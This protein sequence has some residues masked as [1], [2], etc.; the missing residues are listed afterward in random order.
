[1]SPFTE[2]EIEYLRGQPLGRLATVGTGGAPHISPVGFRVNPEQGTIEIG[3]H[4]MGASKKWRDLQANQQVAFVI[5]DLESVNPWTPRGI[6]IRGRAEMH[7][8]GGQE[9]FGEGW[10][11]AWFAVVPQ[12]IVSWGIERPAFSEG[13]RNARSV[14]PA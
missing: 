2:K 7:D 13:G 4:G 10:D 8:A 6:E 3:G 9:H 11:P 12:R 14:T 1:M 5:D